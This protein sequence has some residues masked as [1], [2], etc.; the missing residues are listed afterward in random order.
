MPRF[1]TESD[2]KVE[3]ERAE[4]VFMLD[5]ESAWFYRRSRQSRNS[6]DQSLV[7][8]FR[9]KGDAY[10]D[11]AAAVRQLSETEERSKGE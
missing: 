11:A 10:R 4:I 8:Y 6:E 9:G 1:V 3:A 5:R 7:A 2:Q